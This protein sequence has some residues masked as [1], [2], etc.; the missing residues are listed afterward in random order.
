MEIGKLVLE[1]GG[2]NEGND[3]LKAD[4]KG[5]KQ[6]KSSHKGSNVH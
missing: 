1:K 6:S 3:K 2:I 4:L 5:D